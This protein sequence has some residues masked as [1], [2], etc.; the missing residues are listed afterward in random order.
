[1]KG[2]A[3][4]SLLLLQA[5]PLE[6]RVRGTRPVSA[7]IVLFTAD[8]TGPNGLITNEYAHF[9]LGDPNRFASPDWDMTSGSLFRQLL[10]QE[11]TA[12]TGIPDSCAP[13]LDPNR[14]ST[15]CTNSNVFRVNTFRSFAG[16]VMVSFSVL[17]NGTGGVEDFNGIHLFM[18]YRSQYDLYYISFNRKDFTAIIKRKVPCG[19]SNGG[20]YYDK[21][22]SVRLAW[23]KGVWQ[24]YYAT[25]QTNSDG[26]VTL[27]LYNAD[28]NAL[29]LEGFDQGGPN[30]ATPEC[31]NPDRYSGPE[32]PPL[33]VGGMSGLRG[34]FTTFNFKNFKVTSF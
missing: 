23:T 2:V 20:T 19:N 16:N 12:W 13:N 6:W 27:R 11:N 17:N 26:S 14:D 21:S 29:L 15:N 30:P 7:G 8:L 28:T 1:M 32:Y 5:A 33:R 4:Q 31:T 3:P 18:R 9:N 24:N 34:D 22:L 25:V 10:G